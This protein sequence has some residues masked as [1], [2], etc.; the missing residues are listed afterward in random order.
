[1]SDP[2]VFFASERTLLAWVRSGLTVMGLGFVVA[3]FGLF[4]SHL[5]LSQNPSDTL[6]HKPWIS[7]AVGIVLLSLGS[8]VVVCALYNHKSLIRSLPPDDV[9]RLSLPWL[10]TVLALA[11]AAVGLILAC[12]LAFV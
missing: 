9:P 3:K 6:P 2:R 4:L 7:G 8:V 11:I 10:S 12:Y 5:A 1:M